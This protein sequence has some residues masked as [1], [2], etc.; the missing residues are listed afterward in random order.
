MSL[1]VA[2]TASQID[3]MVAALRQRS[4][5]RDLRL[6]RA[7][8][9]LQS[10][11]VDEYAAARARAEDFPGLP[12]PTITTP[13]GVS[14]GA[15]PLPRDFCVV[16]ADG[17][18]IDVDRHLP[19]R[20]FL[21]NTGV[22]ALTYG[23][24]SD[25]DL[26]G[27][28]KLYARDEELVIRD[29]ASY[30]EQTIEGAVLGAKR[31]VEEIRELVEAVRGLPP[32]T[33]TVALLD[34]S[35]VML[36]LVGPLNQDFVI[37]ELVEEGFAAALEELREMAESRSLA[38]A[39]YISLPGAFEIV[40][41]LRSTVCEYGP[42]D[43]GY[44]CGPSGSGRAPCPPCVGG[45]RDREVFA[46]TLGPGERSAVFGSSSRAVTDYYGG[47][48]IHFFYVHAGEEIGRV[49]VP[50][51][52]AEDVELLE[53]THAVVV[54]QC[55]RGQGYP[56]A[57]MEAHEQAAVTGADRR[58]FVQQLERVLSEQRMPV[59]TSEKARSKRIRAL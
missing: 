37:R 23:A 46:V 18:H 57:L 59:Y 54:D 20:C 30:R 25:A 6:E 24:M 36:G 11:D 55:R 47:N 43:P 26:F 40:N 5:D 49:E 42:V 22:A 4:T 45:I 1:D 3:Q 8:S 34:G 27:A 32:E 10:L 13:P 21:I 16:A 50:T 41:A 9:A 31:N 51:W 39:S 33:P 35:L 19:V 2:N 38:L 7:V 12:L 58:F 28:A 56:V 48:D 52:V 44:R 17:S 29:D 14:Y 15:A 53:L